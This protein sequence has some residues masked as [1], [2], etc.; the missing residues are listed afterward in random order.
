MQKRRGANFDKEQQL[1]HTHSNPHKI[2]IFVFDSAFIYFLL[3]SHRFSSLFVYSAFAAAVSVADFCWL[4]IILF[5]RNCCCSYCFFF[6]CNICIKNNDKL[7]EKEKETT[8]YFLRAKLLR[9]QLI[10]NSAKERNTQR[11]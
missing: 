11:S 1:T 7:T 4:K 5:A 3:F 2:S 9:R 6:T 10:E 8:D